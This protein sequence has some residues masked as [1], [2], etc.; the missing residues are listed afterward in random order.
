M[1]EHLISASPASS[2]PVC[3]MMGVRW[4]LFFI[5]SEGNVL[6]GKSLHTVCNFSSQRERERRRRRRRR[7][8]GREKEE[9]EEEE[10]EEEEEN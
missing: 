10:K 4:F 1:K 2:F 8:V 6:Q 7:W 3:N 9:E 5:S